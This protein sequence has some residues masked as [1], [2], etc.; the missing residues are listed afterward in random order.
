MT[1]RERATRDTLIAQLEGPTWMGWGL[2]RREKKHLK[3]VYNP[4]FVE[5]KRAE[6]EKQAR[7]FP[8]WAMLAIVVALAAATFFTSLGALP[9]LCVVMTLSLVAGK[10]QW[11][12]TVY[13]SLSALTAEEKQSAG[14]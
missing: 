7:Y 8:D 6:L 5:W 14:Q 1:D 4:V 9:V 10:R 3:D 11:E 13:R 12:L 2:S